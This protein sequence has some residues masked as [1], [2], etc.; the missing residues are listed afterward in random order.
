MYRAVA[1]LALERGVDPG[2]EEAVGLLAEGASMSV[3]DSEAVG[4]IVEGAQLG[5][6]LRE[7]RVDRVVS[8]VAR[9]S[10]VRSAMVRLQ[11]EIAREG[12]IVVVGRDIGTVVLPDADVKVY[13]EASAEERARRRHL[14]V[15]GPEADAGYE[16]V[17]RDLE[18]RDALDSGRAD[19]PLTPAA[20]AVVLRTDGLTVEDVVDEVVRIV[21]AG[22]WE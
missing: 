3:S 8:L 7:V 14:E 4:V 15:H 18:R 11:R 10:N 16:G 22:R 6:E 13:L 19:S 9:V 20:D 5:A 1:W 12:A 21:E 17:L 2:D